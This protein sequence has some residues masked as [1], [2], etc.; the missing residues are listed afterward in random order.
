MLLWLD[1]PWWTIRLLV[2]WYVGSF[3]GLG[4]WTTSIHN[5]T[6]VYEAQPSVISTSNHGCGPDCHISKPQLG[7]STYKVTTCVFPGSPAWGSYHG[8]NFY[9]RYTLL[10]ASTPV[11]IP[12]TSSQLNVKDHPHSP[13]TYSRY[14]VI[15]N[16]HAEPLPEEISVCGFILSNSVFIMI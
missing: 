14:V 4:S 12:G 1:F 3:L 7:L 16:V 9:S 15:D 5:C 8:L 6:S 11:L 2:S 10:W 13:H